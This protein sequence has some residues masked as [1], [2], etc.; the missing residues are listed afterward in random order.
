LALVAAVAVTLVLR[1]G[2][3][4]RPAAGAAQAGPRVAWPEGKRFTYQVSWRAKTGGEIAPATDGRSSQ[5]LALE[6][7]VDGEIALER[8]GG[9]GKHALVALS[10]TR[11]EKFSFGMQGHDAEGDKEQVVK[12]LV[13]QTAF[14][15][16]DDRGRIDDIAFPQE[17]APS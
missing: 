8:A 13:G 5:N 17:M 1:G 7:A 11:L 3:P 4:P 2:P 12:S 6:S 15:D 9:A 14:L 10:W 16:I